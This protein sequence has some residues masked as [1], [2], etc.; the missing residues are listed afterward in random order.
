MSLSSRWIRSSAI[1]SVTS[2]G[3]RTPRG[4]SSSPR[5]SSR[6]LT[7]TTPADAGTPHGP[8]G[9]PP[10]TSR[11]ATPRLLLTPRGGVSPRSVS[12]PHHVR[13]LHGSPHEA[14]SSSPAAASVRDQGDRGLHQGYRD[15]RGSQRSTPRNRRDGRNGGQWQP[16]AH[17]A[18]TS[19]EFRQM[20]AARQMQVGA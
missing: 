13:S 18:S 8:L 17:G 10:F 11:L 2:A 20:E 12:T 9:G 6:G 16:T 4:R 15:L 14:S 19:V 1:T 3:V 7:G 5:S